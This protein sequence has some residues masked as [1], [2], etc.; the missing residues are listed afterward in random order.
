MIR[1]NSTFRTNWDLFVIILAIYNAVTIPLN[2]AFDPLALGT[3]AFQAVDALVDLIFLIDIV[4]TFRT[5]FLD[6]EKGEEVIEP[7]EIAV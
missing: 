5:T 6:P 7:L 3:P 1:S 2:I 4:L